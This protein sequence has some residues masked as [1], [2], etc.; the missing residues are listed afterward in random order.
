VNQTMSKLI[1]I[2]S[3]IRADFVAYLDGELDEHAA[4]RIEGVLAHS[5]VARNDVE[6]LAQIYEL[7][8][9]LPRYEVSTEFTEQT[10]ASIRISELRPDIREAAWYRRVRSGLPVLLGMVALVSLI[11]VC[12]LA[13]KRWVVTDTDILVHDLP[14]IEQLDVYSEVG[15]VEFLLRLANDGQLIDEMKS[16]SEDAGGRR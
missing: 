15:S 4:E 8:D 13:A 14:V 11:A 5:N 6:G 1:R 7:L 3:E 2:T 9:V 16:E 10:M 12:F